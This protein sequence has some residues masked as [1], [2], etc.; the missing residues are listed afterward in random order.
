M[1]IFGKFDPADDSAKP[2]R[3]KGSPTPDQREICVRED[4]LKRLKGVCEHMPEQEFQDLI[5]GMTQEQL[6]SERRA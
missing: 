2:T 3:T 4:L 6:R 1:T 5:E